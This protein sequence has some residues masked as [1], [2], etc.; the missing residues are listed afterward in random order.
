[1]GSPSTK[2]FDK[3]K[4]II[5]RTFLSMAPPSAHGSTTHVR[6]TACVRAG[7]LILCVYLCLCDCAMFLRARVRVL[8]RA[9]G[10]A[11]VRGCLHVCCLCLCVHVLL[12]VWLSLLARMLA[13]LHVCVCV[14]SEWVV[15]ALCV[16]LLR[17]KLA[18]QRKWHSSGRGPRKVTKQA[19]TLPSGNS[20]FG[21]PAESSKAESLSQKPTDLEAHVQFLVASKMASIQNPKGLAKEPFSSKYSPLH[22]FGPFL[23]QLPIDAHV[24]NTWKRPGPL[25]RKRKF[26]GFK[27]LWQTLLLCMYSTAESICCTTC[28][29]S[30]SVKW[31]HR[32]TEAGITFGDH[33]VLKWPTQ[34]HVM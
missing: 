11:C 20:K 24:G 18:R 25:L 29:Q 17:S 34:T 10:A 5:F 21:A 15:C 9:G 28:A 8:V 14:L 22:P 6:V 19:H 13:Y 7:V 3:P 1:M 2:A 23:K 26:S 31:P 27:S 33:K 4:S 30:F 12:C 16:V 32:N